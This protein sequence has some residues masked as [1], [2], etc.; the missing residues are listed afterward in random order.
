MRRQPVSRGCRDR[1]RQRTRKC[2]KSVF[3]SS[4]GVIAKNGSTWEEN[5]GARRGAFRPALPPT[6]VVCGLA[7]TTM[8]KTSNPKTARRLSA[9]ALQLL[10]MHVGSNGEVSTGLEAALSKA[11]P[12]AAITTIPAKTLAAHGIDGS[13]LLIRGKVAF[14]WCARG[15]LNSITKLAKGLGAEVAANWIGHLAVDHATEPLSLSVEGSK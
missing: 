14:V 10:A 3:A 12:N 15:D 9:R 6:G 1:N 7:P 8:K 4:S 2:S 11:G 5:I 13:A